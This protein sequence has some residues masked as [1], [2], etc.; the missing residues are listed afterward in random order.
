MS[1]ESYSQAATDLMVERYRN[2]VGVDPNADMLATMRSRLLNEGINSVVLYDIIPST[3]FKTR[4]TKLISDVLGMQSLDIE[5]KL[6]QDA[7]TQT[8][9]QL[10][11]NLLAS[12]HFSNELQAHYRRILNRT[13]TDIEFTSTRASVTA[14]KTMQ[15][16]V[17]ALT[18][19]PEFAAL[20][21]TRYQSFLARPA[22][23][24]EISQIGSA[25]VAIR[26]ATLAEN[27]QT[28]Y[29]HP[30]FVQNIG[31]SYKSLYGRDMDPKVL[32]NLLLEAETKG[33]DPNA[34][35]GDLIDTVEMKIKIN[36]LYNTILGV[37]VDRNDLEE[38]MSTL[39]RLRNFEALKR[40]VTLKR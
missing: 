4:R 16:L 2:L 12:D 15:Q 10:R 30:E 21:Q 19:T 33:T 23:P 18:Q 36:E 14:G 24:S 22:T 37:N 26:G 31:T 38:S 13:Y 6:D 17:Q 7:R 27:L 20:V 34:I 32:E 40:E 9:D 1:L 25:L 29:R 3:A 28:L 5:R 11:Q 35:V 39:S 8:F